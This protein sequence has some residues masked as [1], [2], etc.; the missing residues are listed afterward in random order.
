[1]KLA[2]TSMENS[3][4]H[5]I[6]YFGKLPTNGD[7]IQRRLNSNQVNCW[8]QWLQRTIPH[9]QKELGNN[10]L[11]CY[12]TS[13]V[14]RFL[15]ARNTIDDQAYIGTMIPSMDKVGR[16]FPFTILT[17]VALPTAA[18]AF[19]KAT[20]NWF[21]T[22]E[23]LQFD[24][25]E[26]KFESLETFD[27]K[28]TD[29]T[30]PWSSQSDTEKQ[31]MDLSNPLHLT[32]SSAAAISEQGSYLWLSQQL[33]QQNNFS[34]WWTDGSN[35]TRPSL[36][37][38]QGLPEERLFTAMLNGDWKESGWHSLSQEK[39]IPPDIHEHSTAIINS[40]D[41]IT[42][43]DEEI[44]AEQPAISPSELKNMFL[45][46]G[47]RRESDTSV[48]SYGLSHQ[49]NIREKNE[50]AIFADQ[51]NGVYVIADGMGGHGHGDE[52][53]Q[54][55]I[56]SLS[57][58]ELPHSLPDS[59]EMVQS[60]LNSLNQDINQSYS[61]QQSKPPGS[62]VVVLIIRESRCAFLWAGD[63]RLYLFRNNKL[64]QLTSDH[65]MVEELVQSGR[66]AQEDSHDYPYKNIITRAVGVTETLKLD[67]NY[68]DIKPN[69][70]FLLCSDGLYNELSA[71]EIST[72][73]TSCGAEN[74]TNEL[75]D[76]TLSRTA[77][78]NISII[79][80]D[81]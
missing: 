57:T 70:R 78:D 62:T 12:L 33:K 10:W 15:L 40:D 73:L 45:Q 65:S 19:S 21:E 9:S 77:Q 2:T 59:V 18:Q 47:K 27:D 74:A 67:L 34:I 22:V 5:A 41:S 46:E 35:L 31:E 8:D 1:M 63:S 72:C 25:L 11:Q 49:G 81:C 17:P 61:H 51:K 53:S 64:S 80:S 68:L 28:L 69:D 71:D 32:L 79:I 43:D 50:D 23:D 36:L 56:K 42:E 76:L 4:E 48:A 3:T 38:T 29:L 58:L 6:G 37:F 30:P 20:S 16:Y 44:T 26:N 60:Q 24:A 13:P 55:I 39:L 54:R 52:V 66:L 7:F 14:W 75:L